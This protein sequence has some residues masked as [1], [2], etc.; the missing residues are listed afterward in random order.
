M[1]RTFRVVTTS[2][3]LGLVAAAGAWAIS[4]AI[5]GADES[6]VI[7]ERMYQW[8]T[9]IATLTAGVVLAVVA[10]THRLV[11]PV[12]TLVG[13][14]AGAVLLY[15]VRSFPIVESTDRFEGGSGYWT[16]VIAMLVIFAVLVIGL[17]SSRSSWR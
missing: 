15:N 11:E 10:I 12:L 16:I 4:L 8:P 14:V 13:G 17:R 6:I 2:C 3:L 9:V 1:G 5:T 7:A